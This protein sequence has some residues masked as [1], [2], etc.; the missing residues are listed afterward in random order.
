MRQLVPL[1]AK[2]AITAALLYFAVG[3]T[4]FATIGERLTR[5]EIGWM[6]A[7]VAVALIQL[8]LT[9]VRWQ[10]IARC[11]DAVL[12][13]ARAFRF[14]LIATFFNQ[15]LPST[16]GGDAVRIWL[17]ARDGTGWSRS[18]YSVLLDRFVGVL[19]LAVLV[20]ICLPWAFGLI[21]NPVGRAALLVIGF[22]SIAGA[23]CFMALGSL[24]WHR[25]QR[26]APTRHLTQ[27]A[28][29]ARQ[30]LF[31]PRTAGSLMSI[32]LVVQVL[33]AVMAWCAARAVAAPV[34]FW[35]ALLLVPPVMLIA[36]IP[37]SIAGWGVREKSLVMAFGYAGLSETDGF[38]VSVL[39]GLTMFVV[40]LVGG[41]VWLASRE[42]VKLSGAWR[43]DRAPPKA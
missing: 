36:T 12:P 10:Q 43:A 1:A 7:A 40:G 22:G 28:V 42:P 4:D 20:V 21:R 24:R 8:A 11:C 38:L 3:R 6:L 35:Q 32:S 19:A 33:T 31:T 16:I 14:N 41:A 26:F 29:T 13:L 39:F 25:L 5:V 30:I 27:L 15:V 23:L 18:T 17:F 34:E 9:S 37:I 2:A